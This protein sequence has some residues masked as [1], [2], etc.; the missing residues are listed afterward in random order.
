MTT[1]DYIAAIEDPVRREMVTQLREVIRANIDPRFE[2]GIQYRCIGWYVPHAIYP[3]GYHCDPKEPVPFMGI[4]NSKGHVSLHA[5]CLYVDDAVTSWFETEHKARTGKLDMGKS[6]VRYKKPEQMSL[7]LIGE[8]MKK[9][10]L[11]EF[12]A[13]YTASIPPSKK[14]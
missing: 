7:E 2:E 1:D 8:L 9:I 14:K 13:H 6:C 12:L 10:S 5:F 4:A 3:A 11:D